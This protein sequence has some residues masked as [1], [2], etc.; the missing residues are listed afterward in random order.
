MAKSARSYFEE[1]RKLETSDNPNL[2]EVIKLYND[3]I[4]L[5]H[6]GAMNNLAIFLF[7]HGNQLVDEE[8]AYDRALDLLMSATF[9]HQHR[10]AMLNLA[11][12]Y[13]KQAEL[14]PEQLNG[15]CALAKLLLNLKGT[16]DEKNQDS[17][18][19][20]SLLQTAV[21]SYGHVNAMYVLA[22]AYLKWNGI[23]V[24][25]ISSIYF[26][27]KCLIKAEGTKE[28]K[29][30]DNEQARK[31]LDKVFEKIIEADPYSDKAVSEHVV[32]MRLLAD[33]YLAKHNIPIEDLQKMHCLAQWLTAVPGTEEE[34]AK[35]DEK[36]A[37]LSSAVLEFYEKLI[38][39]NNVQSIEMYVSM[40]LENFDADSNYDAEALSKIHFKVV[41][42]KN[43]KL[44][45]YL[46]DALLTLAGNRQTAN[47]Q[48][49]YQYAVKLYGLAAYW[50]SIESR[51]MCLQLFFVDFDFL[52]FKKVGN[53]EE[54]SLI[55]QRILE[56][57][58]MIQ[59]TVLNWSD[60]GCINYLFSG[61]SVRRGLL[62]RQGK[63]SEEDF[64]YFTNPLFIQLLKMRI[65]ACLMEW[66]KCPKEKHDKRESLQ[67]E[68]TELYQ[69]TLKSNDAD[70]MW[71]LAGELSK[72]DMSTHAIQLYKKARPLG[73]Q[74]APEIS[75][76]T[77]ARAQKAAD[78][79]SHALAQQG[80]F[81][82]PREQENKPPVP[83]LNC[84][85]S[86]VHLKK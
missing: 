42:L 55:K 73:R 50:G 30:R 27:A 23:Q 51:K 76:E 38:K 9:N 19:A 14:S 77:Y 78:S 6:V 40:F 7:K 33:L 83:P 59:Q 81:Q 57:L 34:E 1:A 69:N 13:L 74:G 68:I 52:N 62:V 46:A 49:I 16:A 67:V 84:S 86:G 5:G 44:A 65:D 75:K 31:L 25:N 54:L 32:A 8:E 48:N 24:E 17:A 53:A 60:A 3:A 61:L 15:L 63:I 47:E 45:E 10:G 80:I 4:D 35:N 43:A 26:L 12:L 18:T 64:S 58:S 82:Q 36:A 29:E 85:S 37:R 66:D 41:T 21:Q 22:D 72:R 28:E 79:V 2:E 70:L 56:E 11:N 39:S 71:Y 20:L